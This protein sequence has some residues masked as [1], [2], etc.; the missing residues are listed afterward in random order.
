MRAIGDRETCEQIG[1]GASMTNEK[2]TCATCIYWQGQLADDD[3]DGDGSRT[4]RKRAPMIAFGQCDSTAAAIGVSQLAVFPGTNSDD[5][6]GE[7]QDFPR[8][9]ALKWAEG[10]MEKAKQ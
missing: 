5:W 4:C 2:P 10:P 7:H 3:I 9:A 8:Y 1:D 6:C